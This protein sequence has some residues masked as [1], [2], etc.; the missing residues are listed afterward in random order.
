[1]AG[2]PFL[3]VIQGTKTL[4]LLSRGETEEL[5]GRPTDHQIDP[6]V[7][8]TIFQETGGHPFLTQ[9]LMKQLCTQLG[10]KLASV[11]EEHV[12][13]IVEKYFD[14]RTDFENWVAEFTDTER[15]AYRLIATTRRG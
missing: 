1:M 9:Y 12:Q 8:S 13:A 4:E 15:Q 11:T 10:D 3:N 6:A 7:V 2:S 5:V 14:E